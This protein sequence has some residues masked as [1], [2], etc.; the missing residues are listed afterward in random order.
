MFQPSPVTHATGLMTGVCGPI[1]LGASAHLMPAWEPV[2]GLR[3]I[4]KFGCTMSM[5][6]TPFVRMSLDAL[7]Q[8]D[9]DVTSLRTWVCAGGAPIP[10]SLL[11]EWQ[12]TMPT[13]SLLPLYGCSE[14]FIITACSPT[15]PGEK[16]VGSDGKASPVCGSNCVTPTANRSPRH[17]RRDLS[18]WARLDAELLGQS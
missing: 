7:A 10:E 4:E 1:V 3:R 18:R 13:T 6:A 15:D 2:D 5:T 17:R 12:Q 16:I 11:R 8:H 9:I 14:G